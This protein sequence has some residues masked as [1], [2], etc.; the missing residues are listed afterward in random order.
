MVR[1]AQHAPEAPKEK[2]KIE[3]YVQTALAPWH[4]K[5]L[6]VR[7]TIRCCRMVE[8]PKRDDD[9]ATDPEMPELIPVTPNWLYSPRAPKL[10]RASTF[11]SCA[12]LDVSSS[13]FTDLAEK[14][15]QRRKFG[16]LLIALDQEEA[17]VAAAQVDPKWKSRGQTGLYFAAARQA[18]FD[19][20]A[21]PIDAEKICRFLMSRMRVPATKRDDWGQS[22]LFYA[23]R[24]GHKELCA[25]FVEKLGMSV[26][27]ADKWGETPMFY[28]MEAKK[29]ETVI[30]LLKQGASLGVNNKGFQSPESLAPVE[31]AR[32]LQALVQARMKEWAEPLKASS[33]QPQPADSKK[34]KRPDEE[35]EEEE[36]AQEQ[37]SAA[38]GPRALQEWAARPAKLPRNWKTQLAREKLQGKPEVI[39]ESF[40][41][42]VTLVTTDALEEV[43][44]LEKTLVADQA[45]LFKRKLFV[46]S[47][48]AADFCL[49]LGAYEKDGQF[50]AEY[51]HIV[52]NRGKEGSL[53]LVA[54]DKTTGRTVGFVHAEKGRKELLIGHLKVHN[55][56]Q[57]KGVGTLLIR[58]AEAQALTAGWTFDS[59]AVRVLHVNSPAQQKFFR[60]GFDIHDE[61]A[62]ETT[63][64][65][66]SM[67]VK[68]VRRAQHAPEA[69]KEKIK[70]EPYVQTALAPW[71]YK[72]LRVRKTIRCCRMVEPPKR[73]DDSATDP[74]MPE[75][76]PV[77]PNWLYSPRAPK[78]CRAST[79]EFSADLD[80]SSSS[81]TDL[82]EKMGQRRKFGL[83][84][85]ALDGVLPGMG[86]D[87]FDEPAP[88]TTMSML[89]M[90]IKMTRRAQHA[91]HA[92][93]EKIRIE[94]Y[95][96][97]ALA[98]WH[99]K[100]LH[101][102]KMVRCRA[103]TFEPSTDLEVSSFTDLAE[104]MGKR[105]QFGLVL[106]ALGEVVP[107]MG[108]K[109]RE[110]AKELEDPVGASGR[111]PKGF[112]Q[113]CC[114]DER[115]SEA[116]HF[117]H[118]ATLVTTDA[119]EEVRGLEETLVADQA[120]LFKKK[121]FVRSC[122]AADFCLALGA[123]EKDGATLKPV[124]A[125]RKT[126]KAPAA[127]LVAARKDGTN[128]QEDA[129]VAAAQVDPKWKSRGQTAL[130]FAAARQA[131]FD[132]MA[133]AGCF[134]KVEQE[135]QQNHRLVVAITGIITDASG[136]GNV[137]WTTWDQ[138]AIEAEKICRFLM[139]FFAARQGHMARLGCVDLRTLNH[140]AWGETPMFYAMEAK[141]TET[142]IYLL[143][144]GASLGVNNHNFESP[145]SLAPVEVARELQEW[146]AKPAKLP[147]N[148][149]TQLAREKLKGEPKV[150]ADT[151]THKV[152]LVTSDALE[153]V[154]LLEKTLV[155]DQAVLFKKKLFVRA[156]RA[157]D[158]C[159]ALGAYE[160]DG[161]FFAEYSHIVANRG[162]VG[163]LVLVARDKMTGRIVGFVH[164]EK[165][166]KELLIGHL[167]VHNDHQGKGVG[168]L[169]IRAAEAQAL[170]AGWT[171]DSVAVRVLYVNSP[172]QQKFFRMGFDIHDEPAPETTMSMLSMCVK[173][174][175]RAQHAPEAPKEKIKIEP[176]VQT[177]L[178]PWHYKG[179]R[180]RKTIRCCRMVEP[181]KRDDDSATDPEMP[182]LIPVTPNWLYSPRAPKLFRASTF[183]SC[184]GLDVSS[185]S[186]TDL[187]EK[188]GQRRKFGLL[189]IALD[190]EE[191]WVAAAQV[192]PKWKSRGQ[193]ALYFAAARQAGFD[194]M[195][196]AGSTQLDKDTKSDWDAS[197][198][199]CAYF[200]E[201]LGMSVH[202]AD[203][204][205]ETP[206]FYAM[207]AK[208][209]E[210]V[211]YLLK[212]GASLGVNNKGFQSPESLAPVEV[213]RELQALVQARMKEWAEPLKASSRQPQPADSKKRK[214][215]DEEQEEEEEAQEQT[216]AAEGPRALQ[217][218]A[219]RPAK[220]P[221]NW[222]TQLAREKLQGKPEV[223][224]ES[225]THKVTLVTTD[226]LEEVRGLEKTLV[227]DQAGLFKRKLFVRSCRAADFCLALGAYEK[228]GQF[229][230]EYSHIVANRGKEGS[231]VLVARDK[232][233]GRT[234]GFVHA[235][236]G[237]KE[238]LIGHLKVHNDHQGKG[239]GTLLIRAAEAQALTAGWA[240]DS[241]AVRVLY[242]NSPAQHK[243]FRMGFDIFDE[244][245]PETTMSMLSMCV[246]MVRRAQHAPEAPKEKIKIEPYVQTALAPWHYKG[247]RVRKTIRCC[248]MV[249]P[250]KR[251]DDS[252]TDP[253]MPELIPVTPNWLYSPSP[254]EFVEVQGIDF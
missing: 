226:A 130:Y 61:P 8:P 183:E 76:I 41:H 54:R 81:F 248:R 121:L 245:A 221:R 135:I 74:E 1:R 231:L 25:Y 19:V 150:I 116:D 42:K 223:I 153:E 155:A 199:L 148:W 162:K 38:E 20:M 233:T 180:V 62:P 14:M 48:R 230:A 49:A 31:V 216:S 22:P 157:A 158:F 202:Q 211:I 249:E 103:S 5:G 147:R 138:D 178:A 10:F 136:L 247:L 132:A 194:V 190:Q 170:T 17:W 98:P 52:A 229:F 124:M 87:I 192:D 218:W 205:G 24:Q 46:R 109:T 64:S 12:G 140:E 123:Y 67:C 236:K 32:E 125:T 152:T 4:Y 208:K 238:L 169:L 133:P 163:S 206:M 97:T 196:A 89:S 100:G 149:K 252:A 201:K 154:R 28:A 44:G 110:V 187:A 94:P 189:L 161:Q 21:D 210:T 191:A 119:L 73:D 234:V 2:I 204:W 193:T 83:L 105:R 93:K 224:A 43:R 101:V 30:Y 95:V 47:C 37:T 3:P 39:A 36:E 131:G 242:V 213:A 117:T 215:P 115:S 63:M 56:H 164:A 18:G 217:E 188:M 91:P 118:K 160:K 235:E 35:Q 139:R 134:L 209:T 144:K 137:N 195:A 26:H 15:G 16:L 60:M 143:K 167:K 232:T 70:I 228:D 172:A 11:E 214:R 51:S 146:A 78:L 66:L 13:S 58:A 239:V 104:K 77:T 181:P 126:K 241:V 250:P 86:F 243:F 85:I 246:K 156:C 179:L 240:F 173:M 7:K 197:L 107:G 50:F 166:K 82:A 29:T 120:G 128:L 184:A 168:T 112:F 96:Q 244:P 177:A 9:S 151:F 72:G 185:S 253:E 200:V 254:E 127:W 90:C 237:R 57:G 33:R 80:V 212:Q 69:P 79:F 203:K 27:Q 111:I 75:L 176:Y 207:E 141:K 106:K 59:V 122:R 165:G 251:D 65:M 88:E 113:R 71:H 40:T 55:D 182:E 6:R 174:V 108:S 145:E 175:R 53:V 225:F 222:K 68:M 114:N 142:V 171:F 84:L 34:R 92:P 227:A 186:F 198:G 99:Y 102:R 219:A 220:L 23:A 45:G 129:W 159:L